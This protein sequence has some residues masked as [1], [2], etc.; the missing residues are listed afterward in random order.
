MQ[1]RVMRPAGEAGRCREA[2]PDPPPF[3]A[4][5]VGRCSDPLESTRGLAG[6]V[7]AAGTSSRMRQPKPLLPFAG[8]TL[9]ERA[10][11]TFQEAGLEEVAVVVGHEADRLRGS[12][13][14][15][16]VRCVENPAFERGMYSSVVAGVRSLAPEVEATFI[17]PVDMPAVRAR[18]VELLARVFR[19]AQAAVVYPM[20]R[21]WRGHPPLIGRRVFADILG[22]SGEGGLERVL[23][24]FDEQACAVRVLD[25]GVVLDLDTPADYAAACAEFGDRSVPSRG[26]CLELLAELGV[27][28]RV[29]R[30]G[31][32]VAEVGCSIARALLGAGIRLDGGLV[33]SA[34]LLHDL[35]KGK[36]HHALE[37][38]RH[39]ESL[40]FLR[41][42]EV[43]GAHTDLP[44]GGRDRLD[45]SSVVY[46]A[47]KLVRGDHPVA[48][49]ERFRAASQ[50]YSG[51]PAA[52][53]SVARRW[54]DAWAIASM[55]ERV[56]GAGAL[57]RLAAEREQARPVGEGRHGHP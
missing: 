47:D 41:V 39:L 15:L 4:K 16:G 53:A 21:G 52:A 28:E 36:P 7:L 2:A 44:P 19:G 10:V 27:D 38:A 13:R 25:E 17:L 5:A 31:E 49:P 54:E 46:L 32:A 18:T 1:P 40:G 55:L 37:A 33:R 57:E 11:R 3:P 26:E 29:V 30:H 12:A 56:L 34:G 43:V 6:L 22:C 50:S 42:A 8:S 51:S 23:E 9:L 45:E 35:A 20:F 24:R 48:L 14:A